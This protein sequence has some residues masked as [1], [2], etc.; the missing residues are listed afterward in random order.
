MVRRI[1]LLLKFGSAL[2]GEVEGGE[3]DAGRYIYLEKKER[4]T[5]TTWG[6]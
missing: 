1:L 5:V 4:R 2:K 3:E 6:W